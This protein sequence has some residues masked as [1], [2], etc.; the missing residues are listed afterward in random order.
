MSRTQAELGREQRGKQQI[1]YDRT[2]FHD[3][4]LPYKWPLAVSGLFS[5]QY[6]TLVIG[7]LNMSLHAHRGE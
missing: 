5:A 4:P 3:L 6:D 1:F 2:S 7:E